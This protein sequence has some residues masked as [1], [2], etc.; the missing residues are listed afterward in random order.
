MKA[1]TNLF[2]IIVIGTLIATG[3]SACGK[4]Q[5]GGGKLVTGGK[6]AKLHVKEIKYV[7]GVPLLQKAA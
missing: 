3:L 7:L 5:T 4:A 2:K 6:E 1:N